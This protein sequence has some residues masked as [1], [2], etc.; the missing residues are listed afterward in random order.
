MSVTSKSGYPEFGRATSLF[1]TR[2]RTLGSQVLGAG[3]VYDVTRDGQRFLINE[4]PADPGP[5]IT[6]VFNWTAGLNGKR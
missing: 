4:P 3:A 2:I 5:P 1:H 6:V